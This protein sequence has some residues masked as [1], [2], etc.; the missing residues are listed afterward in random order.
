MLA[1]RSLVVYLLIPYTAALYSRKGDVQQLNA[2]NL[3]STLEASDKVT[4][5]EFYAPWCGHCK[6]LAPIYAKTATSLKGLV[7]VAAIDCDEETNKR[8]CGEYGVQGF[9]TIKM[10]RP[11][12]NSKGKRSFSIEDYNGPRTLK[13]IAEHATSIMPSHVQKLTADK[14]DDFLSEQNQTAKV[15]LFTKKGTTSSTYKGLSTSFKKESVV[16]GQLRDTQTSAVSM[17]GIESFPT[18]VVLPGGAI[19]PV[20][21]DGELKIEPMRTFVAQYILDET[22]SGQSE[23][24]ESSSAA[25]PKKNSA[26]KRCANIE[27]FNALLTNGQVASVLIKFSAVEPSSSSLADM[28]KQ[29]PVIESSEAVKERLESDWGE[30]LQDYIYLNAKKKWYISPRHRLENDA[31]VLEFLDE[32]KQGSAGKKK[33]F[34]IDPKAK[35]EL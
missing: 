2:K 6:N 34:S 7:N 28:I 23:A 26:L 12:T 31:A 27:E 1:L 22:N 14:L 11:K 17:F 9:P 35:E 21:Y 20:K 3:K 8:I 15:L 32:V 4:V 16:F 13:G 19:S 33:Q 18:L 29:L 24:Q 30:S 10:A 25:T 5:L